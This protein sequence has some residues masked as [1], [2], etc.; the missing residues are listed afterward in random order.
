[1]RLYTQLQAKLE[2]VPNIAD[3]TFVVENEG[4]A[5]LQEWVVAGVQFT[6]SKKQ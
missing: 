1:M 5:E 4:V 2:R 3:Y 6:D